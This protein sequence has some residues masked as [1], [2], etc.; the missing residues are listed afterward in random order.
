MVTPMPKSR[1]RAGGPSYSAWVVVV[2]VALICATPSTGVH[3]ESEAATAIRSLMSKT[4]DKPGNPLIVGPIAVAGDFAI[5]SW[6]QDER[7]GRVLL[8]RSEDRWKVILCAGDQITDANALE[9]AGVPSTLAQ[10]LASDIRHQE[11]SVDPRRKALFSLFGDIV[12][13][14]GEAGED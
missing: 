9:A 1:R 8:K 4:W 6:T 10:Q 11:E 5:A 2:G 13:M 14:E 3:T 12:P 7:G